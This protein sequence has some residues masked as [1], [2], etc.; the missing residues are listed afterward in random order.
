M[1][2]LDANM[3][4]ALEEA[5]SSMSQEEFIE[6]LSEVDPVS[7]TEHSRILKGE[8]FSFK[9]RGYLHDIYRDEHHQHIL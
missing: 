5:L 6:I 1:A 8:P 7:W 4:S 3:I 9:D 2:E